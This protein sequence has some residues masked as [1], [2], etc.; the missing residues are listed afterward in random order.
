MVKTALMIRKRWP[1]VHHS[2][3]SIMQWPGDALAP[4]LIAAGISTPA[5]GPRVHKLWTLAMHRPTHH[6]ESAQHGGQQGEEKGLLQTTGNAQR[7]GPRAWGL[8][9]VPWSGHACCPLMPRRPRQLAKLTHPRLHALLLDV[10]SCSILTNEPCLL[11]LILHRLAAHVQLRLL[12][13]DGR[14]RCGSGADGQL[15]CRRPEQR[16]CKQAWGLRPGHGHGGP[17]A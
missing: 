6:V 15:R 14:I 7:H 2:W 11:W 13:A 3:C 1:G 8:V 16:W 17:A 5:A 4:L 9:K 12:M 10:E